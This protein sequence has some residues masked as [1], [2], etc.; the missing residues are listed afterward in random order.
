MRVTVDKVSLN[1]NAMASGTVTFPD[2]V[3]GK[4]IV[5]LQGRPGLTDVS[6]PRLPPDAHRRP[7]V[8]AGALALWPSSHRGP[9]AG[10]EE[11]LGAPAS[12]ITATAKGLGLVELRARIAPREDVS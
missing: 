11:S 3:T 9:G 12:P 6:Q 4:W 1:P 7:G 10:R 2:G 8:H 5:D